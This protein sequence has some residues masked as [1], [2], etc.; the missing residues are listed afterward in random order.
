MIQIQLCKRIAGADEYLLLCNEPNSPVGRKIE[1]RCN[2]RVPPYC[3][4]VW[5][6]D[7]REINNHDRRINIINFGFPKLVINNAKISDSGSYTCDVTQISGGQIEFKSCNLT[8]K[9]NSV[10][11][12]S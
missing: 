11:T 8:V 9:G 12:K 1:I 5:K 7:A 4:V 6:K 3:N 10:S 2:R